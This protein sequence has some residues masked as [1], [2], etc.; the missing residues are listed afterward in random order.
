MWT[1]VAPVFVLFLCLLGCTPLS[2]NGKPIFKPQFTS[3]KRLAI[4]PPRVD[5]FEI[6]A[7]GI[8]EKIDEWSQK[9]AENVT[10]AIK[11]ELENKRGLVVWN[12][13]LSGVPDPLKA[14]L[15]ETEVLFDAV[16]GSLLL[17]LYG[18][19]PQRFEEKWTQFDYSLGAETAN[20]KIPDADALLLVKGLDQI[21]SAGRKTLQT[22]A[23]L[24][25]AAVGVI[26]IPEM[27]STILSA[28]LVDARTGDIVWY[29]FDRASGTFDLR[30]PASASVFVKNLFSRFP[31]P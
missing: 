11:D 17:H 12:V 18:P 20:L 7:G 28:A 4:L 26:L 9:G 15:E 30:D 6:G 21:S 5:V 8:V 14:Q 19:P 16:N 23:A 25:A 24:A 2:L 3:F 29:N 31:S 10:E 1:R 22:T 27:G 13:P